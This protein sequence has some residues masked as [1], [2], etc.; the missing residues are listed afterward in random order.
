MYAGPRRHNGS[1][2]VL[3]P[4]ADFMSLSLLVLGINS[5]LFH[6]TMRQTLQFADEL[7]MLGLAWSMLHGLLTTRVSSSTHSSNQRRIITGGLATTIPAFAAFY[8][9]TGK[10]IYHASAFAGMMVIVVARCHYLLH[11][12]QPPFPQAKRARWLA[13]GRG[14]LALLLLGYGLW[15]IDL[16]FCAELRS[17]REQMGL[18]WAWALE[19]HG[20][21]HVLT[22]VA[23]SRLLNIVREMREEDQA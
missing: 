14:A 23:A 8:V 6:A 12:L 9:S 13:Q 18:P 11:Y 10:I 7:S 16:E 15:H 19:L 2:G 20:W 3:S 5:F 21:W 22:A 1:V 17:L 4:S